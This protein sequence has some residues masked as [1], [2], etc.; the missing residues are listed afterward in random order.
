MQSQP[1]QSRFQNALDALTDQADWHNFRPPMP[2]FP[3]EGANGMAGRVLM[4]LEAAWIVAAECGPAAGHIALNAVVNRRDALLTS[5]CQWSHTSCSRMM[6]ATLYFLS[7]DTALMEHEIMGYSWSQQHDPE[8]MARF[9]QA[10]RDEDE[11]LS[12]TRS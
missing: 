12:T 8:A 2:E 5:E 10:K 1:S 6:Y 4:E 9:A 3:S 7:D 11:F